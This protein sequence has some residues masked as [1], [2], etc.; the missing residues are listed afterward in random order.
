MPIE[1]HHSSVAPA[2]WPQGVS[3]ENGTLT[4]ERM[5]GL[6]YALENVSLG[7]PDALASFCHANTSGSVDELRPTQ[8]FEFLR[9]SQ[10]LAAA[11]L[12]CAAYEARILMVFDERIADTIVG[13]VFGG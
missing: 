9:E 5:P 3:P 8:V 6:G 11:I 1:E 4:V 12:N 13:A 7:V 2:A 10:G